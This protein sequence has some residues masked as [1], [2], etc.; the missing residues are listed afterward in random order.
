MPRQP[1]PEPVSALEQAEWETLHAILNEDTERQECE[2]SLLAFFRRAWREID[3][4]PF[5]QNWHHEVICDVLEDVARGYIRDAVINIPPRFGKSN[6]ISVCWPAWCWIQEPDYNFPLLG[7]HCSFLAVSYGA[8]LAEVAAVKML[9]LV[10]GDW[11]QKLWGHRVQIRDDQSSRSDFGNTAGGERISNSIEGGILGRGGLVTLIDDAHKLDGVESDS[12]RERTLRA[13]SEGLTTRIT[14]PRISAR[15]MVMQRVHQADATDYALRNW[16]KDL[17]H[18]MLPMRFNPDYAS[19]LDRRSRAGELLWPEVWT[20]EAVR[21][22][23]QELGPYAA[24]AQLQQV[25]V[26]RGGGLFKSD[27][28]EP[29]PPLLTDGRFPT[30]MVTDGRI[31][32]PALEYVVACVDTAFGTKQTNDPS[33]MAVLGVF[34]GEGHGRIERRGDTFVRVADDYGFA[35]VLLLYGWAK[36]LEL[37][38][39]PQEGMPPGADPKQWNS[40]SNKLRRQEEWGLVEWVVDTCR[41]YRVDHLRILTLGQGH[42]LAQE[43]RRLHS[44]EAWSVEMETETGDKLARAYASQ[45]LFSSH[46]IYFPMYEDGGRP[47][48]LVSLVD[49][50]LM[51]PRGRH[52]DFVDALLGALRHLRETGILDRR[53]EFARDEARVAAAWPQR[54]GLPYDL[55][56]LATLCGTLLY[57]LLA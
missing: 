49:E 16:R 57:H 40:V 31:K 22:E 19:P 14:D 27:W 25:P 36:R 42:G 6:L 9:R 7:P 5:E 54:R 34:R 20:E 15:V 18:V 24:A 21:R 17:A 2:A 28:L 51:F 33:A 4:A 13:I 12:E 10:R 44:D 52:D 56:I 35:K 23:E 26:P 37:H 55:V 29:W 11:Y 50:V 38:G 48:W 3:P 53:E 8:V 30:E 41:R 1:L 46:Q 43:L 39:P 45:H 47:S 32:Y